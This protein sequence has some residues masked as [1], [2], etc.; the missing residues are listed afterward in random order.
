MSEPTPDSEVD[1]IRKHVA[2]LAKHFDSVQIFATKVVNDGTGDT[3]SLILGAGNWYARYG[4]IK[5]WFIRQDQVSR[6][7]EKDE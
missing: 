5:E 1:F 4:Q 3:A 6:N 7:K 2:Q